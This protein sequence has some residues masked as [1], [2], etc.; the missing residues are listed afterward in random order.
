MYDYD[1]G[2]TDS[3][4]NHE[5]TLTFIIKIIQIYIKNVREKNVWGVTHEEFYILIYG[6]RNHSQAHDQ[7]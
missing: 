1:G 5:L 3:R 2:L 7:R 6:E 4:V